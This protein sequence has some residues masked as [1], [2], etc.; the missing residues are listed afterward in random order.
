M[1]ASSRADR[2]SRPEVGADERERRWAVLLTHRA[3]L[4]RVA[5]HRTTT[6]EDAEDCVQEA[7]A[8]AVVHPDLDLDRAGAFLTT[9]T[10]RLTAD[11]HRSRVRQLRLAEKVGYRTEVRP[12]LADDVVDHALARWLQAQSEQLSEQEQAV[13][14]ARVEGTSSRD[15]AAAL[16][17]TVRAAESSLTRVRVKLQ[18][19]WARVAVVV[20]ALTLTAR[21]HATV[22]LPMTAVAAS[23]ALG[24][25]HLLPLTTPAPPPLSSPVTAPVAPEPAGAP[26]P[27]PGRSGVG[28]DGRDGADDRDRARNGPPGPVRADQH[29]HPSHRADPPSAPGVLRVRPPPAPA[30]AGRGRPALGAAARQPGPAP[31]LTRPPTLPP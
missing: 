19:A 13:L 20:G 24:P 8:R 28:R 16:G 18:S 5:R 31:G 30:G 14:R 15:T 3:D 17:I 29:A 23:V 11:V 22:A 21:R 4:L 25:V 12:D 2:G 27:G 6:L 9:T 10:L 26:A 1:S 7:L